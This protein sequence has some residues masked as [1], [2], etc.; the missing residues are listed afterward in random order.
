MAKKPSQIKTRAIELYINPG[1][2]AT[3]FR[4]FRGEKSEFDF[5]GIAELRQLLSNE[6][7]RLLYVVKNQ[8]PGSIYDLAKLLKRDFKSVSKDVR[9]LEKF[10]FI[11]LTPETKGK[12]KK[13]KPVIAIDKLQIS[14]NFS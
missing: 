11:T 6:K 1:S 14:I 9:L 12:R 5:S 4:R 13:L 8:K 3:I 10:G 2:L 7:A